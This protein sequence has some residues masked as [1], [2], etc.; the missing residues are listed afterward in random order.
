MGNTMIMEPSRMPWSSTLTCPFRRKMLG[1]SF[2]EYRLGQSFA[3]RGDE[4]AAKV[5][6]ICP[7]RPHLAALDRANRFSRG[8]WQDSCYYKE[9]S[10]VNGNVN[11]V[12][13]SWHCNCILLFMQS[14]AVYHHH[15][16][17]VKFERDL[18]HKDDRQQTGKL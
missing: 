5:A 4:I 9:L 1:L 12:F 16:E 10:M 8:D 17:Q 2:R 6:N 14:G 15:G 18:Q 13:N 11:T 7:S 3:Q